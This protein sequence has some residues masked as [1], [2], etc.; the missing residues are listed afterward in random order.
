MDWWDLPGCRNHTV[1]PPLKELEAEPNQPWRSGKPMHAA[2]C[3]RKAIYLAY[4]RMI[5]G[6]PLTSSAAATVPASGKIL[7]YEVN[8]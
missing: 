2:L 8:G 1:P 5:K 3:D 6:Y 4:E 7:T